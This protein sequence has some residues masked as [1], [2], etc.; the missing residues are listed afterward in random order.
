M[1]TD[2]QNSFIGTFSY[3]LTLSSPPHVKCVATLPGKCYIQKLTIM[4]RVRERISKIGHCQRIYDKNLIA[5]FHHHHHHHHHHYHH[6]STRL[7]WCTRIALQEHLT[8]FKVRLCD[9]SCEYLRLFVFRT[10]ISK[11]S[12]NQLQQSMLA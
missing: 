5:Y 7:T 1:L 2:L 10:N 12:S 3:R 4:L 6:Q 8:K 9:M 11:V